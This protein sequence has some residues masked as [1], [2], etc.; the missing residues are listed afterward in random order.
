MSLA[1]SKD[2]TLLWIKQIKHILW[3]CCEF[4]EQLKVKTK[5]DTCEYTLLLEAFSTC[6]ESPRDSFIGY[7]VESLS[8]SIKKLLEPL[9]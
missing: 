2:L 3:C 6:F 4:L 7:S 9:F 5:Q 1:L 8:E